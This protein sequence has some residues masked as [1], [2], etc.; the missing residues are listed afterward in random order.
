MCLPPRELRASSP[1]IPGAPHCD[2]PNEATLS[3]MT[4][5]EPHET[6]V[7]AVAMVL[8]VRE[9]PI[10][11]ENPAEADPDPAQRPCPAED[12]MTGE[13]ARQADV[14]AEA[15]RGLNHATQ[16]SG[17]V[18]TGPADV[19]NTLAGLEL[20]ATR[21][22]QALTQLQRYLAREH[23]AGRILIVDGPHASDPAAFLI[24]TN[25]ELEQATAAA[26]SL[27]EALAHA[28]ELLASAARGG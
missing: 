21:L 14:A 5:H 11:E 20:L 9:Q 18:L 10:R 28:H 4:V 6:V 8:S 16:P 22:P 3:D 13:A 25:R 2:A 23:A 24:A 15:I 7:A 17:D 1:Q 12:P 27:Q 19:Y 26:G